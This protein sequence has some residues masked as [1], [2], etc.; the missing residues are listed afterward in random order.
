MLTGRCLCGNITCK[1]DAEPALT[2]ICH[3]QDCQ[4]QSGTAFSIWMAIPT[5]KLEIKGDTL[6]SYETIGTETESQ[7][8]RKFCSNCGSPIVTLMDDMPQL[9]VLKAGT[10]D[11]YSVLEPQ[12]EIWCDS[13]QPWVR[14]GEDRRGFPTGLPAQG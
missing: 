2:G 3:C 4:R 8:E 9:A 11:D 6:G 5:D 1:C 7:R 12:L 14:A 13:A 10:L